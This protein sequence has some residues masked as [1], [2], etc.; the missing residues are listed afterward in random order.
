LLFSFEGLLKARYGSRAVCAFARESVVHVTSMARSCSPASTYQTFAF[1]FAAPSNTELRLSQVDYRN[2]NFGV[3]AELVL[4]G[5]HAVACRNAPGTYLITTGA[6][7]NFPLGCSSTL[8]ADRPGP[9]W[10]PGPA[11]VVLTPAGKLTRSFESLLKRRYGAR[12][13]CAFNTKDRWHFTS[14]LCSP[15]SRY[16]FYDPTFAH[17]PAQTDLKLS[18]RHYGGLRLGNVETVLVGGHPIAC[19]HHRGTFLVIVP[20]P[21]FSLDCSRST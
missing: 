13:V 10:T 11:A 20:G 8:D 12:D 2:F 3:H 9:R 19:L 6:A 14:G 18:A 17:P 1:Q 15:L 4:V 5:G 21:S 7:L 16:S